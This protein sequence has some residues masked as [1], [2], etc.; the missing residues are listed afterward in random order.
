LAGYGY[1]CTFSGSVGSLTFSRLIGSLSEQKL[2]DC[3]GDA[4]SPKMLGGE[5]FRAR[6]GAAE[7]ADAVGNV[8]G[9]GTTFIVKQAQGAATAKPSRTF[10]RQKQ[11]AGLDSL[12]ARTIH[13]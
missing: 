8:G 12:V 9:A 3:V 10:P 4:A 11:F 7:R 1:L 2:E 13:H 5:R 6:R